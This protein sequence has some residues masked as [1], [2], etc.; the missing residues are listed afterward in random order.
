MHELELTPASVQVELEN[1]PPAPPSLHDTVPAG[2]RGDPKLVSV[3]VTVNAKLL[4]EL[5]GAALGDKLVLVERR[6]TLSA[7]IPELIPCEA[8]PE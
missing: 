4:P 7:D 1:V 8:S 6:L 5:R 2:A 3:T